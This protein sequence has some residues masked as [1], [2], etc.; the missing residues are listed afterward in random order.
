[1]ISF[2]NAKINLGL[3][4]ISERD[5]GYH[6]IESVFYPINIFDILEVIKSDNQNK[7][8]TINYSNNFQTIKNDLCEKAYNLLDADFNLPPVNVYLHKNIP[9]GA[10]LGRG[11]LKRSFNDKNFEF[12]F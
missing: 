7:K 9:I 12:T 10:G 11:V 3:R 4:I 8:I 2:P 5:D 1:M 6:N